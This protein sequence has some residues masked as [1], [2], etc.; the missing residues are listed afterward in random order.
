MFI[1]CKPHLR[2]ARIFVGSTCHVR[3]QCNYIEEKVNCK[4]IL[5]N[6]AI[7]AVMG[8]SEP[9]ATIPIEMM[10]AFTHEGRVMKGA[11]GQ[12]FWVRRYSFSGGNALGLLWGEKKGKE[13][14]EA[15]EGGKPTWSC[16]LLSSARLGHFF[17]PSFVPCEVL[18]E[19]MH[20]V[21]F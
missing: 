20:V 8:D 15:K 10:D 18:A 1:I 12:N 3:P 13:R 21:I 14:R 19:H 4:A 11:S 6:P 2:D 17:C 16:S 9:P 5:S 7:D